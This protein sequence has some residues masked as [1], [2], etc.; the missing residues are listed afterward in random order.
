[1]QVIRLAEETAVR[2]NTCFPRRLFH[3]MTLTTG[4]YLSACPNISSTF[5]QFELKQSQF[6]QNQTD[7]VPDAE[8]RSGDDEGA[9]IHAASSVMCQKRKPSP[10]EP[11]LCSPEE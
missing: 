8:L 1:M 9:R 4:I 11:Q 5:Q 10:T 2:E 6:L 7:S 3:T